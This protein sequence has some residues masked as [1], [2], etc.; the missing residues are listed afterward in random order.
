MLLIDGVKYRLWTPKDEEKEFHPMIKEHSKEIFGKDSLY[1][2]IKH[3]LKSRSGIGSIPDAYVITLSKPY[4]WYIVEN[5]LASHRVYEHIVPQVSRFV[6]G[7]ENLES[8]REIRDVL[9]NEITQDRVLKA[10]VEKMIYPEEIHRFLSSLVSK[11]P[12]IAIIIDEV[13]DE[14][15]EASKALKRLGET[16]IVEFKT[17]ARENAEN[18]R[19]HLFKPIYISEEISMKAEAAVVAKRAWEPR[20]LQEKVPVEELLNKIKNE[21]TRKMAIKLR[22]AIKKISGDIREGTTLD[23]ITFW[24]DKKFSSIYPEKHGFVLEVKIPR[25]EFRIENLNVSYPKTTPNWSI[26]HVDENTNLSL[27]IEAAK[28]AYDRTKR[29]EFL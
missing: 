7:I 4:H 13:T 17:Y 15:K 1:F 25:S 6:S 19:A 3:K 24:R 29:K 10:F 11:P 18:V 8:Q 16:E 23:H 12:K 14:V 27:L 28:Q 20:K 2:D 26:I 21:K 22:D 9:Y 5:E